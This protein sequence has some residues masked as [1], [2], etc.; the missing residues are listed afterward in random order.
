MN[1]EE[2]SRERVDRSNSSLDSLC[3][4]SKIEIK[5]SNAVNAQQERDI[6]AGTSQRTPRGLCASAVDLYTAIICVT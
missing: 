4:R 5:R 3:D 6:D 2:T 1:A